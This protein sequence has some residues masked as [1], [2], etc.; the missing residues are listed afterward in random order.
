M[1][2]RRFF[3]RT[4][5][6]TELKREI[7]SYLDHEIDDNLARGMSQQEAR[8]QA[9]LKFGSPVRVR[10]ELW[11]ANT[12][13]FLDHLRRNLRYSSRALLRAPGFA[14][15]CVLVMALGIGATTALFTVVHSVLLKPLPFKDPPRLIRLYEHSADEKF[16]YNE[17]AAGVYAEWKKQSTGFSDLAILARGFEYGL[18]GTGGE[19]PEKVRA[20]EC[21]W[22]LFPTLGVAPA[23]GR[24]FTASDDQ[25]SADATVLL[26]WGLWKR[27]FGGDPSILNQPIHLDEKSYT[28]IGV[29]P[30]WFAYPAPG[31]QVW[32]PIQHEESPKRWQ[33][34]DNHMFAVV[35]RLKPGIRETAAQAELTLI[36][37]G[38]HDQHLDN[39]FISKAANSRPLLEDIVG[40]YK[41]PLYVLLAAT[42]CL[43]LIG[44][45][46]VASLLVARGTARRKEL[47]IRAALGGSRWRLLGEH[48]TESFLLSAAGG[49]AGLILANAAIQWF[50]AT[51]QD[52]NRVE[53]IHIDAPVVA[54]AVGLTFLCA[55]FAGFMSSLSIKGNQILSSL[56]ESSRS[57]SAGHS[58]VQVRKWLLALEVGLTVVLLIG[59]GLL[60]KSYERLRSSNL[61]C[62]TDNVLTMHL[63]LPN[64][65][66]SQ[67]VQRLSFFETLLARMRALPGVQ[68]AGITT[69]A[70]G[71]DYGGDNGFL[72]QEH[73][74]LPQGTMQFA[75]HR[76]VDPSYFEALG[77]PFLRGQSFDQNQRLDKANQ[78][79]IS[80][81]FAR[82]YFGDEDPIGKHLLTLGERPYQI[83][84]VVGD[85]RHEIAKPAQPMMYFPFYSG[86][87]SGGTLAVRAS[88]DV[89]SL[90][91]PIQQIVQELDSELPVSDILTMDQI[92]G[93]STLDASFNASLVLAFAVLSLLLAAVGLFG[94]LSYIVSQ[95]TTEIGVR[96][97]IG[98]QR[99]QVLA[100][101]L[102]DG[103]RPASIGLLLGLAGGVAASK[104]IGSLLY[105][106]E[107]LD[108]SVFTAVAIIIFLVASL[109]CLLPAWRAS[110]LDPIQ[111]LRIE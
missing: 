28:I 45:L 96:I 102:A 74:P 4:S 99:S 42:G 91:L 43:L 11:Q 35:G 72:I 37:R 41:T 23:L 69:T 61:G 24:S 90:A 55:L 16:P 63:N 22:D 78:V 56:Q 105:A 82:Q 76:W 12:V 40:D 46:N 25:P 20:S 80:S 110:R 87:E 57:H 70:P 18:S 6:D 84:G 65:K 64:A 95:R 13:E 92:I 30:A 109:A 79:I 15:V 27:R 60:L 88:R 19:F 29:M 14:L 86:T 85:T 71:E 101:M 33:E 73:P 5:H 75:I 77:I 51:R 54:F 62:I 68:F 1:S 100:L 21:S 89:T 3:R 8:R 10:E 2:L 97:A 48:L 7:E 108:V 36:T 81:S 103:L 66:Y 31:V 32:T 104:M 94:V 9:H 44:C 98:A 38:L 52:M 26:S 83:V 34:L 106:V 17:S 49:M 59:A 39:P 107:P 111:A 93:K 53:A 47:A 58:Q 67:P 50:V